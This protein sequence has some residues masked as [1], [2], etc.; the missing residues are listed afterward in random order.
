LRIG[1]IFSIGVVAV[2]L[3]RVVGVIGGGVTGI[4]RAAQMLSILEEGA[5]ARYQPQLMMLEP[6]VASPM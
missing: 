2:C 1:R 3:V 4:D 5:S 6:G